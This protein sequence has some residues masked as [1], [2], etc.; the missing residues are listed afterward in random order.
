MNHDAEIVM[1]SALSKHEMEAL[2][3]HS[4]HLNALNVADPQASVCYDMLSG[5]IRWTDETRDE[6]PFEVISALR[7]LWNLRTHSMR[8]NRE[9]QHR[10]WDECLRL[11]PNWVGFLPERRVSTPALLAEY[12]RGDISL[13]WCLRQLDREMS[14]EHAKASRLP[15]L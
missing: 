11:F 8:N 2:V 9:P 15:G 13:R 6:T 5:G 10:M 1:K 4:A 12:R 3:T 14:G 7:Q